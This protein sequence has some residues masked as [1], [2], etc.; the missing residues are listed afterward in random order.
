MQ[1]CINY[2]TDQC[3][4]QYMTHVR[5]LGTLYPTVSQVDFS[6]AMVTKN[7]CW[8][9]NLMLHMVCD[10]EPFGKSCLQTLLERSATVRKILSIWLDEEFD[11]W[12][13]FLLS[14]LPLRSRPQHYTFDEYRCFKAHKWSGLCESLVKPGEVKILGAR[15]Y[16]CC[17][18]GAQS[19]QKDGIKVQISLFIEWF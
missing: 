17:G 14:W 3:D 5:W 11:H 13:C 16:R 9:L 6:I 7:G 15:L 2:R 8:P 4:I 19:G 18:M 1:P 12:Q 10:P